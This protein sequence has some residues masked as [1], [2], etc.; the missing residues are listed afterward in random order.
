MILLNQW[1][2]KRGFGSLTCNL[3]VQDDKLSSTAAVLRARCLPHAMAFVTASLPC[4]KERGEKVLRGARSWRAPEYLV[5]GTLE[6]AAKEV[7]GA[8]DSGVKRNAS[9]QS[10]IPLEP[11][12]MSAEGSTL[13]FAGLPC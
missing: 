9:K 3:C 5:A 12:V 2:N 10:E 1:K 4:G 13:W 8:G 6:I 11:G 7:G